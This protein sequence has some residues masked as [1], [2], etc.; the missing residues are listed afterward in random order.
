MLPRP[1]ILFGLVLLILCGQPVML[2]WLHGWDGAAFAK[3]GGH[4]D[5]DDDSDRD[6]DDEDDDDDDSGGDDDDDDNSGS[7]GGGDDDDDDSGGSGG[8]SGGGGNGGSGGGN[9]G[10]GG[11]NGG[12]GGGN[13]GSGGNDDDDSGGDSGGGSGKGS[14]SGAGGGSGSNPP[15]SKTGA[16]SG[17]RTF[18]DDVLR[19]TYANGTSE[20]L[21]KGRYE[22]LDRNG[23]VVE[24][25]R[26]S[27]ADQSR[28]RGLRDDVAKSGA[29]SGVKLAIVV[30]SRQNA[31]QVTDSSGWS[32]VV[33]DGK[34]SLTDPNG[35]VVTRRNATAKDI[36]RLKSAAGLR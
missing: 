9:G 7:G 20:R 4:D 17:G 18:G 32:E 26:A 31:V 5:D 16:D 25:R 13:G 21:F 6:N 27:A 3:G 19:L 22:R 15:G 34:Y 1:F 33:I 30:N 11:G 12:S 29:E 24:R 2:A 23:R 10:S 36:A 35:N 8:G 14:G 28:L